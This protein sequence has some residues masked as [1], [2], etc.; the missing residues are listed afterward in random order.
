MR[1]REPADPAV[2]P[3]QHGWGTSDAVLSAD[4]SF[5]ALHEADAETN[6]CAS[7]EGILSLIPNRAAF[8][9][10]VRVAGFSALEILP[11]QPGHNLQYVRGDRVVA[12]ARP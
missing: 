5:A 12:L 2:R 8:D 7:T 11:A 1:D 9:L 4:P 3:I 10:L 6:A